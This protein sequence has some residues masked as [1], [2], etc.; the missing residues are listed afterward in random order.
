LIGINNETCLNKLQPCWKNRK[1]DDSSWPNI[2][3]NSL[4]S[5]TK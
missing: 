4:F 3:G 1:K 5:T 2:N